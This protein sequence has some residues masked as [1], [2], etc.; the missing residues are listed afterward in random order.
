MSKLVVTIGSSTAI[1]ISFTILAIDNLILAHIC[2]TLVRSC[3]FQYIM[4]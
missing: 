2:C 4:N 1:A 3:L